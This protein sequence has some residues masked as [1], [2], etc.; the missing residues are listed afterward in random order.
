LRK[1]LRILGF[2][3]LAVGVLAY[4][5]AFAADRAAG[6][7]AIVVAAADDKSVEVNRGLWELNDKPK[8]GVASIYGTP[9]KG[10]VRL[11]A[12]PADRV[13]HPKEDPSLTLYLART[14]D[15]PLQAQTLWYFALPSTIGGLV[16]GTALLWIA[17]RMKKKDAPAAAATP[18]A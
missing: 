11:V 8:D 14:G 7:D 4:P 2:A 12:P 9:A 15:H 3:G 6:V 5:L 16:A 13:L 18:A 1:A 17:C 10:T